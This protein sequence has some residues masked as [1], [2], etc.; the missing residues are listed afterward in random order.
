M[1]KVGSRAEEYL[2]TILRR[3]ELGKGTKA[4]DIAEELGIAPA[5]VSEMLRKL[6]QKKLVKYGPS[7]GI[8]LTRKGREMGAAILRKHRIVQKFLMLLGV[9]RRKVH[10]E[11]CI[12]EHVV[13]DGVE[14]AL[15]V[16]LV[17]ARKPGMAAELVKRLA[18]MKYGEGGRIL[19]IVG[20]KGTCQRLADMGLTPGT[21]VK[22]GRASRYIGPVEVHA[23]SATLA[24]GRG[25][26]EK[27]FVEILHEKK[28]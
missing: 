9:G 21:G 10:E 25:L 14:R 19:F 15:K 26:A 12:L 7:K 17:S 3:R 2:E 4:R 11:A 18:D 5:S 16:A 28:A 20:G 6:A 24:I 22:M 1:I 8:R 27:I 13:S 23:R